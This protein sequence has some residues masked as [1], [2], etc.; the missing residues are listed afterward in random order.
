MSFENVVVGIVAFT[1][2]GLLAFA[3]LLVLRKRKSVHD[4]MTIQRR[5]R[6]P[7]MAMNDIRPPI[8]GVTEINR[9]AT[10][11]SKTLW[12]ARAAIVD[13][14]AIVIVVLDEKDL[15][16]RLRIARLPKLSELGPPMP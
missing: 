5:S 7:R 8:K 6:M 15:C 10:Q 13:A 4:N 11:E 16:G 12:I 1:L 9:C 3:V 2:L 14:A